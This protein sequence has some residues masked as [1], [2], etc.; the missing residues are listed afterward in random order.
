MAQTY[1]EYAEALFTLARENGTEREYADALATVYGMF[2][3]NPEYFDFLDSP[4]IPKSERTEAIE[5]AFS[6]AIP[7]SVVSFLCLLCE[8]GRI[9]ELEGCVK[10]YN[11]LYDAYRSITV[12]RVKTSVELTQTEKDKLTKKL[13]E[14]T[15]HSITLD[16]SVDSTLLGGM[17]IE[18]DGKILDGSVRTRLQK[19]KEVIGR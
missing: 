14:S 13:E 1:K 19:V 3:E 9:R 10:E 6:G 17:I 5:T 18:L 7:E 15:G 16:C 4:S 2:S 12:A 8:R 11:L